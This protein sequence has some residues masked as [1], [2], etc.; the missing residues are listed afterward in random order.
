A[1]V[2]LRGRGLNPTTSASATACYEYEKGQ[3]AERNTFSASPHG[4]TPELR[5][6]AEQTASEDERRLEQ[7]RQERQTRPTI[8]IYTGLVNILN[9]VRGT[10]QTNKNGADWRSA[11]L[12]RKE[13]F[14]TIYLNGLR[15]SAGGRGRRGA[16]E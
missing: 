4:E 1:E 3:A 7:R 14:E 16:R 6:L 11:P 5:K 8:D 12:L 10:A 9:T 13:Y 2:R 15:G